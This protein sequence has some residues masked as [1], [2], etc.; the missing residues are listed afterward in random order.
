MTINKVLKIASALIINDKSEIL[1]LKRGRTKTFR[2]FWQ[3]PEGKLEENETPLT[4]LKRELKEE[5]GAVIKSAKF[6]DAQESPLKARGIKYLLFR[7]IFLVKLTS[8]KILLSTEHYDYGWFSQ[9][10]WLQLKLLPGTKELLFGFDCKMKSR[11]FTQ[12]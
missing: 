7:L 10:Q 11:T 6:I 4:A 1:L 8:S 5:L 12:F 3:L 9:N 2:G